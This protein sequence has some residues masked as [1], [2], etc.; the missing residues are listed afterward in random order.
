MSDDSQW[1]PPTGDAPP[2]PPPPPSTEPSSGLGAPQPGGPTLPP[3]GGPAAGPSAGDVPPP[4]DFAAASAEAG[5]AKRRTGPIVAGVVGVLALG[6][7]GVFAATQLSGGDEGGAASPE[8]AGQAF[9]TALQDEDV[10]GM[11]DLLLPGERETFRQPLIDIVDELTR[12]EILGE[13]ASL[14]GLEG[15]DVVLEDQRVDVETTNVDDITNITMNAEATVSVKGEELPIGDFLDDA[16]GSDVMSEIDDIDEREAGLDFELPVTVVEDD[17][18]WY[19]SLFYTAAEGARSSTDELIP[20]EGVEPKGGES[21]EGAID[22]LLGGVETLDLETVIAAINPNEAAALQRYAPIFLPDAQDALDEIPLG[23]EV[24]ETEVNVEGSGSERSVTVSRVRIEG[25]IEGSPFSIDWKGSCAVLETEDETID[26]CEQADSLDI[27]E[28]TEGQ[29]A[30]EDFVDDLRGAFEGYEAPGL[31]VNEVDGQW[32]VSPI[33]STFDQLLAVLRV[34]DRDEIE[35]L[36]DSGGAAFDELETGGLFGLDPTLLPGEFEEGP[37]IGEDGTDGTATTIPELPVETIPDISIPDVSIP[38]VSIP[39][40][41][42]EESEIVAG[43]YSL[44]SVDEV[45]T[46]LID[47]IEAGEIADYNLLPTIEF[48][49]C[50]VA[51]IEIGFVQVFELS[52]EEYTA[53]VT[54]AATCFGDLIA[55]GTIDEFEVDPEYLDPTCAAGRNPWGFEAPDADEFFETWLTCLYG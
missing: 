42:A 53:I 52:D 45:R 39:D 36:L 3:A 19:L 7:A 17:G 48:P 8:E 35:S 31:T 24:T 44:A 1:R 29:P 41:F 2:P 27:D 25:D 55:A 22:A 37:F 5:G 51:E 43:C 49:E 12:I 6:A 18:R 16:L 23:W 26:L 30:L 46:C 11:V 28:L 14:T 33:G 34:L 54:E 47:A 50:G 10:L 15:L 32:Y 40:S 9:M 13:D 21:P 20:A 38:D 4:P